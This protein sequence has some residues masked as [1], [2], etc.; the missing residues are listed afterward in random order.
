DQEQV[1]IV[2]AQVDLVA[3]HGYQPAAL[4]GGRPARD[5]VVGAKAA[6]AARSVHDIDVLVRDDGLLLDG[7]T[8]WKTPC[9]FCR[10]EINRIKHVATG[11]K[12]KGARSVPC[13]TLTDGTAGAEAEQGRALPKHHDVHLAAPGAEGHQLLGW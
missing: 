5:S 7:R 3:A 4:G 12:E 10:E 13:Q 1:E 6:E 2:R 8:R 11:G 9:R